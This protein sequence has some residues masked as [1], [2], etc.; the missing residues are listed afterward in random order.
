MGEINWNDVFQTLLLISG[1]S[2]VLATLLGI[3]VWRSVKRLRL[4][5]D[6]TFVEAMR[7]TP[8][9][10][11]LFLDLL[12]LGLD[13]LSAPIA[14][15]VLNHLGLRQLRGASVIESLIPGTQA[16]P[17]MTAAW[18]L[19]RLFGPKLEEIP[20]LRDG[21]NQKARRSLDEI[22]KRYRL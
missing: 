12:D 3:W 22:P 10:V 11:V 21:V 20:F 4:P 5:E 15:V 1:V 2:L 6:A 13:F 17:T 16:I 18:V 8:F 14:W 7:L 19:V 9:S